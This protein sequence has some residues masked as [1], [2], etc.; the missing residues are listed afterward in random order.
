M[1]SSAYVTCSDWTARQFLTVAQS[2]GSIAGT[3][4]GLLGVVLQGVE[5]LV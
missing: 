3:I 2:D 5:V 1:H 4:L